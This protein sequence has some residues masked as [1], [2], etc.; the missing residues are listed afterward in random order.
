MKKL[1][2][3]PFCGEDPELKYLSI[4]CCIS[5]SAPQICDVLDRKG[6]RFHEDYEFVDGVGYPERS[7]DLAKEE[8]I[9][10]WNTRKSSKVDMVH[11]PNE[12]K[13]E[14]DAE[15]AERKRRQVIIDELDGNV[16]NLGEELGEFTITS[17]KSA[18]VK[19]LLTYRKKD[20]EEQHQFILNGVKS[21]KY[22]KWHRMMNKLEKEL[23]EL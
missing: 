5:F 10:E 21:N 2:P 3:C 15:K 4:S 20:G 17:A 13:N 18:R 9:K 8:M 1:L 12:G 19:F 16:H 14:L 11:K 6:L 22:V 7:A 23:F